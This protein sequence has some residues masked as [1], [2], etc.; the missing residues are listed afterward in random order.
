MEPKQQTQQQNQEIPSSPLPPSSS[1]SL[2]LRDISNFKTPKPRRQSQ[3]NPSFKFESPC[4]QFF[5]AQKQ[6][7]KSSHSTVRRHPRYSLAAQKLKAVELEQSKSSRKTQT[8]KEKSLKSLAK[9]LTVWLN[10]LFENPRSCGVDVSRFTGEDSSDGSS[11][12]FLGGKRDSVRHDGI[13]V[14]REWHGPKRRKDMSWIHK[15]EV[16]NKF[17]N[18]IYTKLQNSLEDVCSLDDM[19]ERMTFYLSLNTCKEIFDVMT[20]V[21]KN[22][23]EGRLKMKA[24]CPIVTDVG[25]K[26][27]ALKILMSYNS[28]WLRI[29]LYIIFGGESLLPNPNIDMNYDQEVSFLKMVAEKLFFSHSGLAKAYVYNKLVEGL[30]RPG[31]YEKL[32]SVILKKFL[33]LVIILDRAKSQSSLP[34]SYGIDGVDG[35]SPLLF[36]SRAT[37]KSSS[38]VIS[39]FLSPDVMHGVGNLLT[40]LTIIGYKVSYQ[41]NPLVK[42]VFKVTNLFDDL[43]DGILLC[44]VI[45]L[46]QHDP[47]ILKKVVVPSDD[48]KKNFL[49]CEISLKYLKK[50]GVPLCDEDGTEIIT[51]D[52][53]NGDKELI[54]SL[55]WNMFV[56]LQLPLLINNKLVSDEI[57]KI[58]GLEAMLPEAS[59]PLQMLLEWIKAVCENYDLKVDNFASLVDG[60][61]MW[62]LIDY[63]FR[64]EHSN[65]S[66]N[67]DPKETN[68]VSIMSASDYMDAVHNFLLSQKLTTLLGNFPE[69]LQVSDILEFKG[70]C[71]DR[72]VIIL[73]VFLSSQ[74]IVKRNLQQINFHKLLGHNQNSERKCI[75]R[76]RLLGNHEETCQNRNEDNGRNFKAIMSWWKEMAQHNSNNNVKQVD[77]VSQSFSGKPSSD[78]QRENAAKLIQSYFRRLVEHQKY[79]RIKKTVSFLQCVIRYWIAKRHKTNAAIMIQKCVR[80]YAARSLYLHRIE[81]RA[82]IVC[83]QKKI[84]IFQEKAA[85]RIQV[86]WRMHVNNS[87]RNQRQTAATMIQTCYRCWMLKK[88]FLNHKQ[89]AII[90]QSRYRGLISRKS[91]L[92]Y[93]QAATRIQSHCRG[94]T[95]RKSF[96][97]RK[98]ATTKIQS[99]YRGFISRK[100]F[101]NHKQAAT[102]IQSHYRGRILRK[103][104]LSCKQATI[105]IQSCYHVMILRKSFLTHK[106]A[107]TRI[108]SHY[109]GWI[110]RKSFLNQ[111]QA[112]IT[113]QS[114]Y[115]GWM[116]RNSFL[117]TKQAVIKLQRAYRSLKCLREFK[118]YKIEIKS[119]LIIQSCTRGWMARRVACRHRCLIVFI[120]SFCRGWLMRREFLLQKEVAIRI[121]SA[122]RCFKSFKAFKSYKNA[123]IVIQRSVRVCITIKRLLGCNHDAQKESFNSHKL[124]TYV[125][126]VTKLQRWWR[127]VLLT[128]TIKRTRSA[129]V[130]QSN[131]RGWIARKTTTQRRH[132]IAVIQS[133]W[134]GYIERK[135]SREKVSEIRMRVKKSA[136][137]VDDG[138]R[139]INRLIAALSELKNTNSLSGI[140]HICA[141]L[142][143]ATK[144]S[145]KCCE[146]LVAAG[147]IDT[148]LGLIRSISRSIAE[149]EVL[150][151][152]LSTFRNLT[153]HPHLTQALVD[154][155]G[156]TET[157]F[158]EFVR[159]KE[160]AYFIAGDV[161]RNICLNKN[162]VGR[163]RGAHALVKR[164]HNLV[165]DLKRKAGNEKRNPRTLVTKEQ[166]ERRLKEAVQIL[167]LITNG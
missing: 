39:E 50:I 77:T 36:T 51:E 97:N 130:I 53:V 144:H 40:H 29:G 128:R 153:R 148:L 16:E 13:G 124:K 56:H 121:Q 146:E 1:S 120:Q 17:S 74:L 63:Y 60:K 151:Y 44:R 127:G 32:G 25:M 84:K 27:N 22:I 165:E 131:V 114:H 129:I 147:A 100:S 26:E 10:F 106:Q 5:T 142:D 37:I 90:I 143:M 117:K 57:T 30:Y 93:K 49:N 133:Y 135:H 86:A 79:T 107:A 45:Q 159:N 4:P 75:R 145:Q 19:K 118:H 47:S 62:C 112:T 78:L 154:S 141:T 164:L 138:M 158:W 48:R 88:S 126:S 82:W 42:Y 34:I 41:Q 103:S 65:A 110:Y 52:I 95:L 87:V 14:D 152:T 96:L 132:R 8:D 76:D 33:L 98:Q 167:K 101:L 70:A 125:D 150:R 72:G 139:I 31:Y 54:I 64:K 18:S 46:L 3:A 20:H 67:K 105:K 81:E 123:A 2:L 102:R 161:L 69:V 61:A 163:L 35:G 7:P 66:S 162:G 28:I 89:A 85:L 99:H 73:L 21:T 136:A 155:R 116:S 92:H 104:F 24:H 91:F 111:K 38:E 115:R 157:I 119:A 43:Q 149:Q 83:Q 166:T 134:K 80:G 9:S 140:L 55:L 6:T 15:G 122:F 11:M 94:I 137:N 12:V 23:D 71:S 156:S 160:D 68:E 113:I 58:R 109:R 108:E 59:S